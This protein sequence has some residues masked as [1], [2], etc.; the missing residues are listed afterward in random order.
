MYLLFPV[1]GLIVTTSDC[2][3]AIYCEHL[4]CNM[5]YTNLLYCDSSNPLTHTPTHTPHTHIHTQTHT[6]TQSHAQ[7]AGFTATLASKGSGNLD[8]SH[9]RTIR[10]WKITFLFSLVFAIPTI[11][12]AFAP[13][14]WEQIR[15]GL[16]PKDLVLFL[17]STLIQVCVVGRRKKGKEG[18]KDG[19]G[20]R[21]RGGCC[22]LSQ[23]CSL[24]CLTVC[25]PAGGW[26]VPVLRVS[27]QISQTLCSEHGCADCPCNNHCLCILCK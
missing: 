21:G 12:V 25:F 8:I 11:I 9:S 6:H 26:W 1:T 20:G 22:A 23:Q 19:G 13:I 3:T 7:G 2:N 5:Q 14:D 10:K 15:P 27:I 16:T 17:L 4:A 24:S 18:R